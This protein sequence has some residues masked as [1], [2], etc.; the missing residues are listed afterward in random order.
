M[1]CIQEAY[2]YILSLK[3]G[4]KRKGKTELT[5]IALDFAHHFKRSDRMVSI[6]KAMRKVMNQGDIIV[7]TP[8]KGNST[9]LEIRYKL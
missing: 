6:C 3:E 4:A 1:G 8:P 7:H 9:A 5:I 2:E